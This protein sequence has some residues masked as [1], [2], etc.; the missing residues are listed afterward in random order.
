MSSSWLSDQESINAFRSQV[1][2][3]KPTD[4]R[5]NNIRAVD[6]NIPLEGRQIPIRV[7]DSSH[8]MPKPAIIYVHGGCW[9][10]GS[11]ESH[12]EISRYLAF[13]GGVKVIAIDYRLPPEHQYPSAH[14]DIYDSSVWLW[15]NATEL[16]IDRSKFAIC[17]ES[18]GAYFAAATALRSI[19]NSNTPQFT[20]L[21]TIYAALDGGGSSWTECKE[22]YFIST[23]ESRS[24]YGAPLWAD[25]LVG[26]PP[27][28]SIFAEFEISRAEQELFIRKLREDSVDTHAYMH[29][30]V[31][32]DVENWASV[33]GDLVAHKKAIE[34]INIGFERAA[35]SD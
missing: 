2:S 34:F 25:T 21:L 30:D 20:F 17:G 33:E 9:V 1:E 19:D 35:L 8:R 10:A 31:G 24:R 29:A 27:T 23:E 6:L 26:M 18:A 13:E 4:S 15:S 28:F 11:L 14:N 5:Y 32:H 7:Y 16:G 22:H 12:D 3:L